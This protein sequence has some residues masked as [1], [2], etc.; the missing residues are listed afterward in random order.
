[1]VCVYSTIICLLLSLFIKSLK[2]HGVSVQLR[3]ATTKTQEEHQLSE[4]CISPH[5][6]NGMKYWRIFTPSGEQVV[7]T[8]QDLLLTVL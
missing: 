6:E 7:I 2:Y 8:Q 3:Y 1:M 4:Y 5:I